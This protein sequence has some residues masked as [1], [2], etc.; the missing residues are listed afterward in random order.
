MPKISH[1]ISTSTGS[2]ED[3]LRE[4][5]DS[6]C[7]CGSS[8]P[9]TISERQR[10]YDELPRIT[11][12]IS[13]A[14]HP[15]PSA[16]LHHKPAALTEVTNAEMVDHSPIE[17]FGLNALEPCNLTIVLMTRSTRL[18]V[19]AWPHSVERQLHKGKYIRSSP[20]RPSIAEILTTIRRDPMKRQVVL[21]EHHRSSK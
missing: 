1:E 4:I 10:G 21:F 17:S 5:T 11:A 12:N 7:L 13:L 8:H 3:I 14:V 19:I 18:N 2:R 9:M 20:S 15:A 6:T 16:L